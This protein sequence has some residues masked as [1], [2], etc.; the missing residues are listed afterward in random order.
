MARIGILYI[1]CEDKT[2]GAHV[3]HSIEV[4]ARSA[5]LYYGSTVGG[6]VM[7]I[8][9]DTAGVYNGNPGPTNRFDSW[10]AI[11]VGTNLKFNDRMR[12]KSRELSGKIAINFNDA[13]KN[14]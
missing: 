3:Y 11:M 2:L 9:D 7:L 12:A 8:S 14:Y 5:G 1:R 13:G 4:Y 10:M 6:Y